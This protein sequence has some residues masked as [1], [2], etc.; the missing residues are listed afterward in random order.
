MPEPIIVSVTHR[1]GL[2]GLHFLFIEG[3]IGSVNP[4]LWCGTHL[5]DRLT[6]VEPT[7]MGLPSPLCRICTYKLSARIGAAW[8]PALKVDDIS[9]LWRQANDQLARELE[10]DL[11]GYRA[12]ALEEVQAANAATK[13]PR[14]DQ[15]VN[16]AREVVGLHE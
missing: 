9:S 2:D 10:S 7:D 6:P 8:P 13:Q 1:T 15:G 5:W 3:T 4:C 16:D 14:A 12:T 11:A